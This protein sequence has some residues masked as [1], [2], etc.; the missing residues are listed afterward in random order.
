MREWYAIFA[1]DRRRKPKLVAASESLTAPSYAGFAEAAAAGSFAGHPVTGMYI[2][3]PLSERR[4]VIVWCGSIPPWEQLGRN[5][6]KTVKLELA[7]RTPPPGHK[8]KPR[9]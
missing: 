1:D 2:I 8:E 3:E 6:E 7:G 4:D 5:S 9:R